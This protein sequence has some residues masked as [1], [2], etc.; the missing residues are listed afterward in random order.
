MV[1]IRLLLVAMVALSASVLG[2]ADAGHMAGFAHG[3]AAME[4][5]TDGQPAC[6][7]ETTERSPTCHGFPALPPGVEQDVVAPAACENTFFGTKLLLTGIEPSGP[8]DPP[9]AL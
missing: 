6:C 9:R 3:H 1:F 7:A 8:L 4:E 2:A 5:A